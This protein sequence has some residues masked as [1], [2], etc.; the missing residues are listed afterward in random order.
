MDNDFALQVLKLKLH[1]AY[2]EI[3]HQ[4]LESKVGIFLYCGFLDVFLCVVTQFLRLW[5]YLSLLLYQDELLGVN[6]HLE[7]A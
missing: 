5:R 2:G 7:S 1:L 3:L 6:N 4:I